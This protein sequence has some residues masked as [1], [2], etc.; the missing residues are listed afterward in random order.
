MA[1]PLRMATPELLKKLFPEGRLMLPTTLLFDTTEL[2]RR[3]AGR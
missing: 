1:Y 2:V 3:F